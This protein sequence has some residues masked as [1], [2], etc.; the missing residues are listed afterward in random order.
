MS[1]KDVSSS[2]FHN[3]AGVEYAKLIAEIAECTT[4]GGVGDAGIVEFTEIVNETET[5]MFGTTSPRTGP[6]CLVVSGVLFK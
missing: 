5:S 1:P 2:R 6:M 4:A 3:C